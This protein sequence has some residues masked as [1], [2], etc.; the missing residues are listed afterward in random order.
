MNERINELFGKALDKAVPYTWTNLSHAEVESVIKVFAELIVRDCS[1]I[2]RTEADSN[3]EG[4]EE[5]LLNAMANWIEQHF[6][7]ECDEDIVE[8]C[9]RCGEP[10]SGTSCGIPDCGW[11]TGVE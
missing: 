2:L 10:D 7:V 1:G 6:G 8:T 4:R 9:P 11:V 5:R 3:W